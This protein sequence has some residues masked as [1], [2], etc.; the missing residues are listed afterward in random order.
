MEQQELDK[1]I[2]G[3]DTDA[4]RSDLGSAYSILSEV[5]RPGDVTIKLF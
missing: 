4:D 5:R 1:E 3:A 2:E